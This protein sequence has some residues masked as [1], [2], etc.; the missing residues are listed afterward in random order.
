VDM[1]VL[2]VQGRE[3][4]TAPVRAFTAGQWSLGWDGRTARGDAAA[5]GIY[6]VQ[7]NVDGRTFVRRIARMR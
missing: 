2:D 3:V 5:A 1:R 6:L 4:W 7:V